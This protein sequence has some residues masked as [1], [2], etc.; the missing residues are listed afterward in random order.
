MQPWHK[1]KKGC[2]KRCLDTIKDDADSTEEDHSDVED[3]DMAD[4]DLLD[5]IIER[6]IAIEASLSQINSSLN[7]DTSGTSH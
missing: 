5:E 7:S 1:T 6:L 2:F 3:D 4:E